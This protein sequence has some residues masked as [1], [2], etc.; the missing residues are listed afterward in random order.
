MAHE[1]LVEM[2]NNKYADEGLNAEPV[3]PLP[4]YPSRPTDRWQAAL[5]FVPPLLRPGAHVLELGAGKGLVAESLRA[6]GVPFDT[7]T[8]GDFSQVRADRLRANL[9]D[10]RFRFVHAD[11]EDVSDLEGSFD[12]VLMIALIEHLVDPLR[13]M[14]RIRAK[15]NEGG[16]VYIDT[17]NIAKWTR[18]VRLA[19]GRFPSTSSRNEGLTTFDGEPAVTYDEGHLHYFTFRSLSLMLTELCGFSR[20]ERRGYFYGP[21]QM[22]PAIGAP[23]ARMWP[24]MFSEISCVAFA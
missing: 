16:F 20:V 5:A 3:T 2:Y 4:L 12:A 24:S 22:S 1:R 9:T 13:A 7:Y 19:V 6:G 23:L 18:R 14:Q 15:L 10:P 21:P 8:I 17:P 11:A